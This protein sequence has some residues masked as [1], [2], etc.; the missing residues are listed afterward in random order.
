MITIIKGKEKVVCTQKTYEDQY[1]Q[2]GYLPASE[3]EKEATK[4]VASSLK[5]KKAEIEDES[6]DVEKISSKYGV[7]KKSTTKKGE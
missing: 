3:I 4:K 5:E 1:A 6:E 7:K 2:L